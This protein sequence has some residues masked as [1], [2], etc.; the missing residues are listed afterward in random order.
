MLSRRAVLSG[1]P[2]EV[3]SP[4]VFGRNHVRTVRLPEHIKSKN[5]INVVG[6]KSHLTALVNVLKAFVDNLTPILKD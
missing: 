1:A 6:L 3:L 2:R 4:L 5:R